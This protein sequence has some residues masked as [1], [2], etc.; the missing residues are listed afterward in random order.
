MTDI[1]LMPAPAL[2][3]SSRE[4]TS[5]ASAKKGNGF[6]IAGEAVEVNPEGKAALDG[7]GNPVQE[8]GAGTM[9]ARGGIGA[10]RDGGGFSDVGGRELS[11]RK[12]DNAVQQLLSDVRG[13]GE[14]AAP[15]W[16]PDEVR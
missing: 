15:L 8:L 13:G 11:K 2:F 10:R 9:F 16:G 12:R 3:L 1:A 14:E 5:D 7:M 4:D 6:D